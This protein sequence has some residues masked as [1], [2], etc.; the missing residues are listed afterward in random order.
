[1]THIRSQSWLR[2]KPGPGCVPGQVDPPYAGHE[3]GAAEQIDHSGQV[4][5]AVADPAVGRKPAP[6]HRVPVGHSLYPGGR[7]ER[8]SGRTGGRRVAART[9]AGPSSVRT[10]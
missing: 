2:V 5:E 9:A 4:A 8:R 1:M 7:A 3:V 10:R 6:Q